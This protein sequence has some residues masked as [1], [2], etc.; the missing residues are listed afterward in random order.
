MYIKKIAL[1]MFPAM[2]CAILLMAA[3][4][5]PVYGQVFSELKDALVDYSR[6]DMEPRKAC[7]GLNTF[8]SNEILQIQAFQVPASKEAPAH[9]R[10]AGLLNPEIAFEVSLPARWNGRFYMIGNG[11]H[12]GAHRPDRPGPFWSSRP[13]AAEPS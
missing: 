1:K 5:N 12:A 13:H 2:A 11:G 4:V 8:K 10:V 3:S 9:C 6:A 7:E